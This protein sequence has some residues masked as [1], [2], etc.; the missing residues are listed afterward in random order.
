M[1]FGP[2]ASVTIHLVA[3][4]LRELHHHAIAAQP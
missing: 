2:A 4:V 3:G 1:I